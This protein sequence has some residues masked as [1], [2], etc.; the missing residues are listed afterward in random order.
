MIMHPV[1][2]CVSRMIVRLSCWLLLVHMQSIVMPAQ[3]PQASEVFYLVNNMTGPPVTVNALLEQISGRA[4]KMPL[5]L[6]W[7]DLD[8]WIVPARVR[9]APCA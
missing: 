8:P 9:M 2:A 4:A 6:L 7:G 5:L 3:D 1:C